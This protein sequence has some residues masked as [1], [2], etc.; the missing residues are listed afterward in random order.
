MAVDTDGKVHESPEFWLEA[1]VDGCWQPL[2]W[3]TSHTS[4]KATLRELRTT[5][6]TEDLSALRRSLGADTLRFSIM[7][8][9]ADGLATPVW[10]WC[11]VE[12]ADPPAL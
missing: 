5:L 10:S 9:G 2:A 8:W 7:T 3:D 4:K 6:R 1:R 12:G 11:W